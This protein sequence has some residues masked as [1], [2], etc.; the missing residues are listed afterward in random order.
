M[1]L[2]DLPILLFALLCGYVSWRILDKILYK[3]FKK[4]ENE[5]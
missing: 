3:R 5:K 2:I 4:C 1:N